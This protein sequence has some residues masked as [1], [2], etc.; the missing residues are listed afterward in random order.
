MPVDREGGATLRVHLAPP[1]DEPTMLVLRHAASR[2][3][4]LT[5]PPPGRDDPP[6][7]REP[8]DRTAERATAE[9]EDAETGYL[10]AADVL[11]SGRPSREH[12]EQA[13]KLRAVIIPWAG[14]PTATRDLLLEFPKLSVH[15]LHDNAAPTAEM[16]LTLLLA[17]AKRIVPNDRALR[18]GDWRPRYAPDDPSILLEGK[19]AV[20]L[21]FGAIGRRVARMLLG[22]GM[23]V[24][25]VRRSAVA[26]PDGAEGGADAS[27]SRGPATFAQHPDVPGV[28]VV[29][30]DCLHETLAR[31]HV[32]MVCLPLTS[33]TEGL[34][35]EREL[36][37]LQPGAVLVNTGRGTIVEQHALY[38]ALKSPDHPLAAA[39]I[40]VW[41]NY[42]TDDVSRACTLPADAPL[43]ELDNLVLSPHRAAIVHSAEARKRRMLA[44][45]DLLNTAA[46]GEPMPN[47]VDLQAGY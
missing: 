2:G 25:G 27:A 30:V 13:T 35:G 43:H 21:G 46:R 10:A 29:T 22:L 17:A 6:P 16:A 19:T 11:V 12:L 24:V 47:R 1:F 18:R 26:G 38:R 32:V 4:V 31:A 44:L 36:A 20:V 3:V 15:N 23:T 42:P 33:Q 37:V 40:D 28:E 9:A 7:P 8:F 5:P 34:L 39:G 14:L 41:Y 45:A